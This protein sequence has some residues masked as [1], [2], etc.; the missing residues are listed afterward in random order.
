[1]A[2]IMESGK[3]AY[4]KITSAPANTNDGDS[5]SYFISLALSV[6]IFMEARFNS[7]I[8]TVNRNSPSVRWKITPL[9]C[10]YFSIA[11]ESAPKNY[12]YISSLGQKAGALYEGP[13]TLDVRQQ[14]PFH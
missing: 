3:G 7:V 11:P 12:L 8:P 10:G 2:N 5:P 14:T 4:W 9:E 13:L 1:M 6:N